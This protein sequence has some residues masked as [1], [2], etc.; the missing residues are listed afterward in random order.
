MD[1][2]IVEVA[3]WIFVIGVGLFVLMVAVTLFD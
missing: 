1:L 2:S 3:A